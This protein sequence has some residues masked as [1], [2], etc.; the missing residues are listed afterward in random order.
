M[1]DPNPKRRDPRHRWLFAGIGLV[2]AGLL[3]PLVY[4]LVSSPPDD[5][6]PPPP[7]TDTTIGAD[8]AET[9]VWP[10]PGGP[11]R[12]ASPDEAARGFVGDLIGFTDPLLGPFLQGDTRSGEFEAR[13]RPEGP[14]TVVFVR[15]MSDQQWYVLG[16]VASGIELDMPTA[17]TT[18]ATPLRVAGRARA[19]EGRLRIAVY[20]HGRPAPLG[21][22]FVD[23]GAADAL[24]AFADEVAWDGAGVGA[25]VVVVTAP[26]G[27]DAGVWEAVAVPVR[28]GG[29]G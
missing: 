4:V 18:I 11:L 24:E 27:E 9:V 19:F 8:E 5:A 2:L 16:A 1:T 7:S 28:L 20:A 15:Q 21:E 22:A 25:G 12:F 6:P 26:G 29:E 13:A 14:V 23:A 3:T 17:G 10:D